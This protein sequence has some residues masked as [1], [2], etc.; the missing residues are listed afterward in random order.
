M[1]ELFPGGI[2][3]QYVVYLEEDVY[4]LSLKH[5]IMCETDWEEEVKKWSFGEQSD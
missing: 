4:F 3:S 2:L 1:M 5:I